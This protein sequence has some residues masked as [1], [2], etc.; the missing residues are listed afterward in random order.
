[1]SAISGF[2]SINPNIKNKVMGLLRK[3]FED[4]DGEV[5]DKAYFHYKIIEKSDD[6]Y[7]ILANGRCLL[8]L[9]LSSIQSSKYQVY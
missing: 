1:M 8:Y 2:A 3:C 9:Y 4:P 7:R 6:T 5:R